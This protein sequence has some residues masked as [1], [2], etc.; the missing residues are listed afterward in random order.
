LGK[1][2]DVNAE[3]PSGLSLGWDKLEINI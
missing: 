2:E 3:L 1:H